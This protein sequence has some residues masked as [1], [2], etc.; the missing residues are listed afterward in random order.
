M[1]FQE[2]KF[3]FT[4]ITW[5]NI[6]QLPFHLTNTELRAYE[7][8]NKFNDI[9]YEKKNLLTNTIQRTHYFHK[10]GFACIFN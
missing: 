5:T 1:N 3:I 7:H 2:T 4:N 6:L 10:L 9:S 8:F